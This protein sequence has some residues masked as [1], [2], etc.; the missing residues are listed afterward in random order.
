MDIEI[1]VRFG[2]ISPWERD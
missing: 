1:K 2:K